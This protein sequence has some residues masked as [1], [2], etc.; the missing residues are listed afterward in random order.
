MRGLVSKTEDNHEM[1]PTHEFWQQLS[2]STASNVCS[3]IWLKRALPWKWSQSSSKNVSARREAV[4]ARCAPLLHV[5]G[6]LHTI[7]TYLT[8]TLSATT[9]PETNIGSDAVDA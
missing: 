7:H 5:D 2:R 8:L 4:G 6:L 1:I 9:P 3:L